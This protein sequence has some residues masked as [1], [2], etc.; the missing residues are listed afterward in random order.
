MDALQQFIRERCLANP[1]PF[2]FFLTHAPLMPANASSRPF[3]DGM[4]EEDQRSED[5]VMTL[6]VWMTASKQAHWL[7]GGKGAL[8]SSRAHV[9]VDAWRRTLKTTQPTLMRWL[10]KRRCSLPPRNGLTI[11]D[12]NLHPMGKATAIFPCSPA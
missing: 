1:L 4:V 9:S 7:L 6:K 10:R 11:E 5:G 3:E 12:P 8:T 2:M